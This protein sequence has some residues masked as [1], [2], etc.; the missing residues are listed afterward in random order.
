MRSIGKNKQFLTKV[1]VHHIT[2]DVPHKLQLE[3]EWHSDVYG[4]KQIRFERLF[5]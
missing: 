4:K 3:V 1:I 2:E 5:L